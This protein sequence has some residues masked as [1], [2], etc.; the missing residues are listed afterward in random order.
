M[1]KKTKAKI[2]TI[3]ANEPDKDKAIN[4]VVKYCLGKNW[5]KK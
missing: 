1:S 2:L 5:C 4:K 3:L